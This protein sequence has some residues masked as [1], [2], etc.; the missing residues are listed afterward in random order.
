MQDSE[1][2]FIHFIQTEDFNKIA[3]LEISPKPDNI[4]RVFMHLEELE[5]YKTVDEQ[6][7]IPFTRK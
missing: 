7:L 4:M 2:Y 1:Y 5:D 6:Q 3:P